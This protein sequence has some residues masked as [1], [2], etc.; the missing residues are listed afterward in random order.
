MAVSFMGFVV[1][2][3]GYSASSYSARRQQVQSVLLLPEVFLR[4]ITRA[5]CDV[6]RQS[7]FSPNLA[8]SSATRLMLSKVAAW[9]VVICL[10]LAPQNSN[11]QWK[12]QLHFLSCTTS[13]LNNISLASTCIT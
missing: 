10:R 9:D 6:D 2:M 5:W 12:P 1:H 7:A 8:S 11:H 13:N 3:L 4:Y